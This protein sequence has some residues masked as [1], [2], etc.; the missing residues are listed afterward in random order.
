MNEK[1]DPFKHKQRWQ[2][3]KKKKDI[4]NKDA[5]ENMQKCIEE[6]LPHIILEIK[7]DLLIKEP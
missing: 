6:R 4:T 7:N 1:A 5:L 3:W 2:Q